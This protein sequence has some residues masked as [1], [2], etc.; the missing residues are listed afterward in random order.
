MNSKKYILNWFIYLILFFLLFLAVGTQ[1]QNKSAKPEERIN[2]QK[3]TDENGN[4]TRY[5]STYFYSYS[6]SGEKL[7]VDSLLQNFNRNFSL[8]FDSL[9]DFRFPDLSGHFNNNMDFFFGDDRFLNFDEIFKEQQQLIEKIFRE[10]QNQTLPNSKQQNF[11]PR[12]KNNPKDIK[13]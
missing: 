12:K 5:D 2:V 11:S 3:E 9:S 6:G 13:I 10:G 4:I 8:N 1:G 7:N